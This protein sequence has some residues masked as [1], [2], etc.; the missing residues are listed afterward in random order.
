MLRPNG[1][2]R[3]ILYD[4]GF[5]LE[6]LRAAENSSLH[7]LG[8]EV[9]MPL[10]KRAARAAQA[11]HS[12]PALQEEIRESTNQVQ[13]IGAREFASRRLI[14]QPSDDPAINQALATDAMPEYRSGL[15]N[16]LRSIPGAKLAGNRNVKNP[17]RLAE[18]IEMRAQPAETVSDY[19]AAQ[20]SVDS[21]KAKDAVVAAIK[22]IFPVL[23]EE[24]EFDHGDSQY[25]YRCHAMQVQMANG[26]SQE[27]QIVPREVLDA[28][29]EQHQSYRQAR[30]ARLAGKDAEAFKLR[31][32]RLNDT[33][34]KKF[35]K[36][37][38]STVRPA[39]SKGA[40]VR[41]PDGSEGRI[42][43]LDS[44]MG[45]ARVGTSGGRNLTVKQHQ[46]RA[47]TTEHTGAEILP[48]DVPARTSFSNRVGV[49]GT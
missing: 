9:E 18:K 37:N 24:D 4:L 32:K 5:E 16:A 33:A 28:N 21:L 25:G 42:L 12:E 14:I 19:G 34:M 7:D 47:S 10:N 15:E 3:H 26:A 43:Y 1:N 8:F 27:L 38:G 6:P 2:A 48:L 20:V 49:T 41:L 35:N 22:R 13:P 29:R 45:I 40:T 23:R 39:L 31:A 44:N 36:R 30:D 46:L 11:V 17:K